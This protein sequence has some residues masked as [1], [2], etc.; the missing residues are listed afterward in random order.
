MYWC[1]I[2]LEQKNVW[3]T[4]VLNLL[5]VDGKYNIKYCYSGV[6][7]QFTPG[8]VYEDAE[9]SVKLFNSTCVSQKRGLDYQHRKETCY[10]SF[11]YSKRLHLGSLESAEKSK[12][13]FYLKAHRT[14]DIRLIAFLPIFFNISLQRKCHNSVQQAGKTR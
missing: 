13:M 9:V 11:T 4:P 1:Q 8:M 2:K 5:I 3:M 7:F 14:T 10:W 12:A 6:A